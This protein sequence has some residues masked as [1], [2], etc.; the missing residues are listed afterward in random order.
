MSMTRAPTDL[1]RR[2]W[3]RIAVFLGAL[4]S[5][6]RML[7]ET[8]ICT[9][10]YIFRCVPGCVGWVEEPFEGPALKWVENVKM[11]FRSL[12]EVTRLAANSFCSTLSDL[13]EAGTLHL[14]AIIWRKTDHHSIE[15]AR[16]NVTTFK[17]D[18]FPH[19]LLYL[20]CCDN[21]IFV[22]ACDG[23]HDDT[24]I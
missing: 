8:G 1:A 9:R 12:P 17:L 20:T 4:H 24:Y 6:V 10:R 13:Q 14:A 11:G 5:D 2:W 7:L 21:K 15:S 18:D 19:R 16:A 22:I 3:I 23:D